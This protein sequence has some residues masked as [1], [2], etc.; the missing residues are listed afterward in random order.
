[1]ISLLNYKTDSPNQK[2]QYQW[3]K[4]KK[5]Q[6]KKSLKLDELALSLSART[7]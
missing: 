6:S 2:Q 3:F 4:K 5:T 7:H 1:M